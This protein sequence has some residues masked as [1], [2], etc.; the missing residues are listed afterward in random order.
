[1]RRPASA[2]ATASSNGAS[3][4]V[5]QASIAAGQRPDIRC[6]RS[7][8]RHA[9]LAPRHADF[10]PPCVQL[11]LSEQARILAARFH[12][13][14]MVHL[15]S[16]RPPYLRTSGDRLRSYRGAAAAFRCG[17][18]RE[19]DRR[20]PATCDRCLA[21][22]VRDSAAFCFPPLFYE[23]RRNRRPTR[24]KSRFHE[25]THCDDHGDRCCKGIVVPPTQANS[26]TKNCD[27]SA[28]G[29][30][31]PGAASERHMR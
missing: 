29:P 22:S 3:A 19:V 31:A 23:H 14:S 25:M 6:R 27:A 26:R 16:R 2:W 5:A 20:L 13:G 9:G 24:R 1:M 7:R 8:A 30:L 28:R 18:L 21:R 11:M 15:L 4:R 10:D 12:L 17:E